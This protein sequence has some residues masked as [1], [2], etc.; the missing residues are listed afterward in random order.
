MKLF[1]NDTKFLKLILTIYKQLYRCSLLGLQ[2]ICSTEQAERLVLVRISQTKKQNKKKKASVSKL[3][4]SGGL[5]F[6]REIEF[7]QVSQKLFRIVY[8]FF[9]NMQATLQDQLLNPGFRCAEPVLMFSQCFCWGF[10]LLK[11][12][13]GK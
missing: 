8:I 2:I 6:R 5:C 4:S 12:H 9:N 7:L 13:N 11:K 1:I 10:F 3:T